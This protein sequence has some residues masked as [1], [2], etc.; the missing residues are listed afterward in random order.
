M[1]IMW[2]TSHV[3]AFVFWGAVAFGVSRWVYR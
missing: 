2:I 1:I 3:V